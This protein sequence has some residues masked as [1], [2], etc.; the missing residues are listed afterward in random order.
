MTTDEKEFEKQMMDDEK[1]IDAFI[2][3]IISQLEEYRGIWK[4]NIN[5][6][7]IHHTMSRPVGHRY[8]AHGEISEFYQK[9][10]KTIKIE[11]EDRR[12]IGKKA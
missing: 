4:E 8:D 12:N 3:R 6:V 1:K 2:D 11:I 5:T 7:N 10:A 9:S